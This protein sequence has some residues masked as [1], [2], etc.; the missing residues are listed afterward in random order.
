MRIFWMEQ[1]NNKSIKPR[2]S[3]ETGSLT[4]MNGLDRSQTHMWSGSM[5]PCIT[6]LCTAARITLG[7]VRL[8]PA[9]DQIDYCD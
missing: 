7:D 5:Q 3:T 8:I 6:V 9:D 1:K 4:A 2:V